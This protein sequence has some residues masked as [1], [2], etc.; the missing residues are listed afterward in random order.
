A[1]GQDLNG[2]K[3]YLYV[4][5]MGDNN[6]RRKVKVIYQFE[7]PD[8]QK[9]K[10]PFN[11]KSKKCIQYPF[12]YGKKNNY[13]AEALLVDSAK[14]KF[15]IVS[16]DRE[17]AMVFSGQLSKKNKTQ[18]LQS[19]GRI[20]HLKK[21]HLEP[22]GIIAGDLSLDGNELL[23]R[24]HRRAYYWKVEDGEDIIKKML[25]EKPSV[26][27]GQWR[28]PAGEGL[29]FGPKN[30]GYYTISEAHKGYVS[31]LR[32]YEKLELLR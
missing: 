1:R 29:C 24:T 10:K 19:L 8:V 31:R 13:N 26:F 21:I 18:T 16:K 7:E 20:K 6:G 17:K 27:L 14:Q 30:S 15:Y 12:V 11:V 2:R 22:G 25:N 28:E 23:I 5:D 3:N 32:F 4:G 9:L